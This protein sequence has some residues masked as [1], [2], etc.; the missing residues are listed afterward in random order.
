MTESGTILGPVYDIVTLAEA[1]PRPTPKQTPAER[2]ADAAAL[3]EQLEATDRALQ[4][5]EATGGAGVAVEIR[6][7]RAQVKQLRGELSELRV[8]DPEFVTEFAKTLHDM[9]VPS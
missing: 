1:P 8:Q 3:A 2:R 5:L 4:T 9:A 6:A 7:L